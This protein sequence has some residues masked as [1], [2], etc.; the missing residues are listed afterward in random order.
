MYFLLIIYFPIFF[1]VLVS[2]YITIALHKDIKKNFNYLEN[3]EQ[4]KRSK[5]VSVISMQHIRD[6][7]DLSYV[8]V[9]WGLLVALA[10]T[11]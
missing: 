6:E 9:V 10:N 7:F 3:E 11:L 1:T 2:K 5:W 8:R 4:Y